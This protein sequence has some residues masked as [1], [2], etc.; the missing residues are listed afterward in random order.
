MDRQA[1]IQVSCLRRIEYGIRR[2]YLLHKL[3]F[4]PGKRAR[5]NAV[6]N[7]LPT[8]RRVS[9]FILHQLPT[10]VCLIQICSIYGI[11]SKR[12]CSV[13]PLCIAGFHVYFAQLCISKILCRVVSFLPDTFQNTDYSYRCSVQLYLPAKLHL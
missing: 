4:Y 9:Y 2:F 1:D 13:V 3:Q 5:C 12:T 11:E 6:H 10:G 7:D 8:H